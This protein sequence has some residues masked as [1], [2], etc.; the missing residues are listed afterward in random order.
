M[1]SGRCTAIGLFHKELGARVDHGM[2]PAG[3]KHIAGALKADV[4]GRN[5]RVVL[6]KTDSSGAG[7]Q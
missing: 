5:I 1:G 7:N 4:R 3:A 2:L 6:L